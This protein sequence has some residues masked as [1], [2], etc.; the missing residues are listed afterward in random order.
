MARYGIC[1]NVL[2][3][4]HRIIG[5]RMEHGDLMKR[6]IQKA[7]DKHT[8]IYPCSNKHS[9]HDCFTREDN[10]LFFWFNTTDHTTRVLYAETGEPETA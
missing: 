1:F 2:I 3:Q 4:T 8:N 7:L 9:L 6:L 10:R 5:R